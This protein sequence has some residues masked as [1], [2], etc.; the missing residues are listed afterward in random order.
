MSWIHPAKVARLTELQFLTVEKLRTQSILTLDWVHADCITD[1]EMSNGQKSTPFP[2][3][4]RKLTS[5]IQ[6]TIACKNGL[7]LPGSPRIALED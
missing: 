2:S 6:K 5:A 3:F 4:L 7:E 1:F